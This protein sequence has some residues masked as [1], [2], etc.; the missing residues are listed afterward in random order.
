LSGGEPPK[1]KPGQ[2]KHCS[3]PVATIQNLLIRQLS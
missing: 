3:L 2:N 1:A